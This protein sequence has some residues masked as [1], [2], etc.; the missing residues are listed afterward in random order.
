[1]S[2]HLFSNLSLAL[3]EALTRV[4]SADYRNYPTGV[5]DRIPSTDG[6]HNYKLQGS[7]RS[8]F[9]KSDI[10]RNMTHAEVQ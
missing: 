1:M 3:I 6:Q 5:A 9:M 7:A 10:Q 2:K 4:S 8:I